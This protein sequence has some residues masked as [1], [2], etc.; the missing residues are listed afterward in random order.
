MD[1]CLEIMYYAINHVYG[2]VDL[3]TFLP[4][5]TANKCWMSF[6]TAVESLHWWARC[7]QP[8]AACRR[9]SSSLEWHW[10]VE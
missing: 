5:K 10:A 8:W 2:F 6:V 3:L 4:L 1:L 7:T 9:N